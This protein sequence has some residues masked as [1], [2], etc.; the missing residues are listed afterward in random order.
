MRHSIFTC[1]AKHFENPNCSIAAR[2]LLSEAT[3]AKCDLGDPASA[4][5]AWHGMLFGLLPHRPAPKFPAAQ[6]IGAPWR[7]CDNWVTGKGTVFA[8]K[9]PFVAVKI[10]PS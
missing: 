3:V 5:Q 8:R 10:H 2:R 7:G 9:H 4:P 6:G 1:L